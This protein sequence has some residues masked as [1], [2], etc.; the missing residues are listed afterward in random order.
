MSADAGGGR[1]FVGRVEIL[2]ALERRLED[3]RAG[4][5]GVTLLLGGPGVG[6]SELVA[7]FRRRLDA[8]KI[9]VLAASALPLDAPPPFALIRGALEAARAREPSQPY[10]GFGFGPKGVLIGFAPRLD[11]TVL[12]A[13]VQVEDR[14]LEALRSADHREEAG[15]FSLLDGIAAQFVEFTRRGPTLLLLEDLHRADDPSLGAIEY[16]ARQF[17]EQPLWIVATTRPPASLPDTHRLRLEALA[18]ATHAD[19]LELRPLTSAE[20]GEFLA[21]TEPGRTFSP[22]EVARAHSQTG[23]NPLLLAHLHRRLGVGGSAPPPPVDPEA[24]LR[25]PAL[26]AADERTAATAAVAGP[27]VPFS[28]L[29]RATGEDE[30]RLAESV[31]RLVG[32]G[33]FWERPAESLAFVDDR[34]R[35][36]LYD[37]LPDDRRRALHRRVGEAIE[38]AGASDASTIYALARHYYLGRADERSVQRNQAAA[39]IAIRAHSPEVAAEHL[40][41]AL[42]SHR[43]VAPDD[44]AGETEL[45]VALAQQLDLVGRL[46]EAEAMLRVHLERPGLRVRLPPA[47]Y[48]LGELYLARLRTDQGNWRDAEETIR[49]I[50][51][52]LGPGALDAHPTVLIALHR[53]QGEVYYYAGR[54]PEAL[55]EHSE[56]LRLAEAA[57][58]E[59]DRALAEVRRANVLAMTGEGV[60]AAADVRHAAETLERLGDLS[61]AAW[62]RLFVGVIVNGLP[63]GPAQRNQAIA[64]FEEAIR[65]AE[66]AH[67]LRR[68]A[69]TLFN[70]A[71]VLRELGRH[72]EALAR[73]T[74]AR[75]ILE[76][77][78]DRFGLVN[79]LIVAGKLLIDRRDYDRAEVELLDAYRIVRE[80]HAPA[81]EVDVVLRLAELAHARGDLGSARR[82]VV[83]LQRRRL[84]ELRPDLA[85]EFERLERAVA[86]GGEGDEA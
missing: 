55:A 17:Q 12:T 57:G 67:D 69:W 74:R 5:G 71:D 70:M 6:K 63:G 8:R 9:P 36:A 29:L 56:E 24:P 34:L 65:L 20:V 14:L 23:G 64:E 4:H 72:D 3:A 47:V 48:A 37:R 86:P 68:V 83:E 61:E 84:P 85:A 44:W 2:Q 13:P 76:R 28:T 49:G 15:H 39:E 16:L 33:L 30:E 46:R 19:R 51:P 62:A 21:R 26:D 75:E 41:R 59:L 82:R 42:E 60:R 54:Y 22:E 52:A 27:E 10:E 31:D 78:G 77:I 40:S 45:T 66:R 18:E 35:T 58:N 32:L 38:A 81:D 50:V 73:N 53:L 1:T 7:E 80:L 25:L 11:D 43:R 79:A